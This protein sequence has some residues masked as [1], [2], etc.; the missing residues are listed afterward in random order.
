MLNYIV[1][2][3]KL[4]AINAMS[5]LE[6][7]VAI[8]IVFVLSTMSLYSYQ[9]YKIKAQFNSAFTTAEQ[10]KLAISGYYASNKSCPTNNF[11]NQT[12]NPQCTSTTSTPCVASLDNNDPSSGCRLNFRDGN[13][14]VIISLQAI[15]TNLGD[16]QYFCVLGASGL[17]PPSKYLSISTCTSTA[18]SGTAP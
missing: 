18:P 5:L 6:I 17:A 1:K 14:N 11:I 3:I 13:S 16:L 4:K 8:S 15:I 9:D 7:I 12:I 10:N 2:V